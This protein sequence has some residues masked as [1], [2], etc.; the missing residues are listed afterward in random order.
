[1]LTCG[2]ASLHLPTADEA[3]ANTMLVDLNSEHKVPP[4][5]VEQK[6]NGF[7]IPQYS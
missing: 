6:G 3:S 2:K 4:L 1:M 5:Q 7:N